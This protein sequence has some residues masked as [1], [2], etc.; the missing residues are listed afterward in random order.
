MPVA[1]YMSEIRELLEDLIKLFM[2]CKATFRA[3]QIETAILKDDSGLREFLVSNDMWGG[4]GSVADDRVTDDTKLRRKIENLMIQIG[5][6][7]MRNGFVNARTQMWVT[8]FKD[9]SEVQA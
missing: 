6:I 8:A 4:S 5:S 1:D 2:D 9:W 3:Q 7:Q